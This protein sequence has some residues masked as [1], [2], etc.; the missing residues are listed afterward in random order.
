MNEVDYKEN[1]KIE[2]MIYEIRGKQV[3]LDRDLAKL[4]QIETR[5][6]NQRVKRNI[7]RFP[8][9]FCFQMTE[10]EFLNW[11]SQ[12]VMSNNDKIGLRRAPYVFAEQGVAMLSAIINNDIAVEVSIR[13]IDAF[14][15]M[16]KYIS[17][18]ILEQQYINNQVLK[19]TEDIRLLQESFKQFDKSKTLN[20]IFFEGQIYDAYSLLLDIFSMANKE[21]IIIDNFID[22]SLLDILRKIDK[23]IIIITNK[24][25]NDDYSKYKIQYK[26][27]TLKINN[28]IH[29][30][31]IIIDRLELYHCGASLKDLGKKCF[32]INKIDNKD[33]IN[34]LLVLIKN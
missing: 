11:K 22:K 15:T 9:S 14:V 4:Y 13:I 21:I 10:N 8:T 24:Y 33:W 29:D 16:R 27:I 28:K 23:K 20:E 3:M 34:E 5:V 17:S 26:N 30:R 18:N 31:F 32:A 12:I 19:N 6:L 7:E 2:N 1:I 25:N